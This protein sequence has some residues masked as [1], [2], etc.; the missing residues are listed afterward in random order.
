MDTAAGDS[1]YELRMALRTTE[2]SDEVLRR[3][4]QERRV[5]STNTKIVTRAVRA[6]WAR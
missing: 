1:H 5:E 6:G 4:K 3:L 2:G